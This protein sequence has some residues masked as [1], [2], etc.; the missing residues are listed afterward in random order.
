MQTVI[1]YQDTRGNKVHLT[2]A[3][4]TKLNKAGKW[5]RNFAG[6]ELCTVSHGRH[7]GS[8]TFS[9]EELA[10]EVGLGAI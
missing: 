2:S 6:E 1:T 8:P 3:Q 9:D 7:Y 4:I 10:K 5:P